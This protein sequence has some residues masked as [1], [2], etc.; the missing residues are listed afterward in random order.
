[1]PA[2]G[3]QWVQ[4]RPLRER[5]LVRPRFPRGLSP[6]FHARCCPFRT[7][8]VT[9]QTFV[10]AVLAVS[11]LQAGRAE[12]LGQPARAHYSLDDH[13]D[14]DRQDEQRDEHLVEQGEPRED[15]CG[16]ERFALDLGVD[17]ERHERDEDRRRLWY[18]T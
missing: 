18:H 12:E 10:E 6:P 3:R 13:V 2:F 17:A 7:G 14:S 15:L 5:V 9:K 8:P 4:Q 11:A 16:S 1:M